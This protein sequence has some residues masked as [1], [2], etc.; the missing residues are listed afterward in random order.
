MDIKLELSP[1]TKST[2]LLRVLNYSA[3]IDGNFGRQAGRANTRQLSQQ[4]KASLLFWAPVAG[5]YT[6]LQQLPAHIA[7]NA[8]SSSP[9]FVIFS[10]SCI[11]TGPHS[12][13]T[14]SLFF[15]LGSWFSHLPCSSHPSNLSSPSS[16]LS[17]PL[18][19]RSSDCTGLHLH[20]SGGSSSCKHACPGSCCGCCAL[21]S[22]WAPCQTGMAVRIR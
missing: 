4:P 5:R 2:R 11:S 22:H 18:L 19:T 9:A 3:T 7:Q 16:P 14:P 10:F 6:Q 8:P 17:F 13:T 20:S 21:Y 12:S 1:N 15:S